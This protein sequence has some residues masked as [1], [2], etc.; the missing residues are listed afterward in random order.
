[1]IATL[2]KFIFSERAATAIEYAVIA[3]GVALVIIAAM[4]GI[5]TKLHSIFTNVLTQLN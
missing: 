2:H 1:M 5:G 3:A 4:N